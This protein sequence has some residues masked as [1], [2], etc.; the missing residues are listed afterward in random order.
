MKRFLLGNAFI[1]DK[2]TWVES[3][4]YEANDIVHTSN[5]IYLSL[6]D[7]NTAKTTDTT[8]WRVWIDKT[9]VDSVIWR[10][11]LKEYN[12]LTDKTQFSMYFIIE[13]EVQ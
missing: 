10:G 4:A 3:T 2:G 8:A 13:E 12:A 7:N 1:T 11:T 6:V 9:D 5:G